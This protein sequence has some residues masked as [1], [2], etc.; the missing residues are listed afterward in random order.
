MPARSHMRL[1]RLRARSM[2]SSLRTETLTLALV[3]MKSGVLLETGPKS[4]VG[5]ER[6]QVERCAP[7]NIRV[8]IAATTFII[9]SA[10][11]ARA[12][13]PDAAYRFSLLIDPETGT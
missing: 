8:A 6:P 4:K 12:A 5:A 1:K 2:L 11:A 9:V 3:D 10:A 7:V 13:E